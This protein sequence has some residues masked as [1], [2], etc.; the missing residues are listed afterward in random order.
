MHEVAII[1]AGSWGTALAVLL[2][3]NGHR[4]GLWGRSPQLMAQMAADRQ[5]AKYL[6]DAAL[7]DLLTPTSDE[8]EALAGAAFVVFAVPSIGL[9]D[10]ARRV[11]EHVPQQA[12]LASAAKGL[13]PE[14]GQ[15][16]CE[17]IVEELPSGAEQRLV[18]L[19]GPNLAVEVVKGIPTAAVA[20]SASEAASA[21]VQDLFS[22][23]TFR[24]YTS[25]DVAGVELGGALKN[26]IAIGAGINDGLGFGDNT[27]AAL[28]TRGLV[29]MARLV[30]A[31]GGRPETLSGLAGVGDLMATCVS[32]QSRNWG[33]GYR[34]GQGESTED[35][36]ASMHMVAEGV[37]T[38]Q[39][40][41]HLSDRL[42]VEMPITQELYQVIYHH[43]PPTD[44]VRD[45]MTRDRK[46]E[47]DHLASLREIGWYR[48][49]S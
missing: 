7:P 1:G 9:R 38:T 40:A 44:A 23:H 49:S 45:L 48:E 10:I 15:R 27:K 28:A 33:V 24:V 29:E 4:V 3:G 17:V 46:Q 5:N 47:L 16:M 14:T 8:A 12:V 34:L 26:I 41:K 22:S 31:L 11:A 20:A 32:R 43:K 25:P 6:P 13:E 21:A 39:A 2:A 36:L 18:A 42:G 30:V 35:I 19:S 37:H